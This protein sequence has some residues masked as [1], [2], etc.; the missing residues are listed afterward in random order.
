MRLNHPPTHKRRNAFKR[1]SFS[2]DVIPY[3]IYFKRAFIK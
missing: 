2:L 3:Q 1:N